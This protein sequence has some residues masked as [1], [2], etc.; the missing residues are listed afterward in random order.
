MPW[1][2]L[3]QYLKLPVFALVASRIGG[4]LMWQP[5]LGALSIP[6]T[7]R[8]MLVL[9]LA[10]LLTPLV[11]LPANAQDTPL[12]IALAMGQEVLLGGLIGLVST[13]CFI[14]MQ[15]GGLLIAQESGI[16]FGQIVDPSTDEQ[17]TVLGVLYLQLAAVVFLIVGGH[18]AIVC[19]C[20][21]TFETIPLLGD[22]QATLLGT[23]VICRA[24]TLSAQLAFR[25]ATPTL[26]VLFLVNLAMGLVSRTMPQLNILAVGFSLKA[27]IAFVLMAVSIPSAADAFVGALQTTCAWLDELIGVQH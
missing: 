2:L 12:G 5:L 8:A 27:L 24:L 23:D 14:G 19:A 20:L 6:Y 4:L 22:N 17:E 25:I 1:E 9:A 15:M 11:S 18:R 26:L 21:D 13:A 16:A 3:A 7:L 10:A